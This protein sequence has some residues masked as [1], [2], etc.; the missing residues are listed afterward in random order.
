MYH[1]SVLLVKKYKKVKQEDSV[2]HI[3]YMGSFYIPSHQY[4]FLPYK[5]I[6]V[7]IT[8]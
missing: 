8:R 5:L 1:T 7:I 3:E 4:Y 6:K 2:E